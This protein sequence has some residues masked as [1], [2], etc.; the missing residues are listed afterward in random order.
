MYKIISDNKDY[1]VLNKESGVIIHPGSGIKE[2]TLIEEIVEKYPEIKN[3]G[4]D[5]KRPG[6]VQRL[7]KEASGLMVIAKNTTFF[8]YLK[9]QFQDRKVKKEYTALVYGQIAK[10]KDII[11]FPIKRASSGHK[12]AA[13]PK[14][15]VG[16]PQN[17]RSRGNLVASLRAKDAITEFSI[18]KR[19]INYTLL[20]ITIE[21]GRT[22]QIRVHMLAY[23]HPLVGDHLYSTKKTRIKNKKINLGRIFLNAT[24]LSFKDRNNKTQSFSIDLPENLEKTLLFVKINF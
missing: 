21:T 8:E 7:D 10:E 12:M 5:V 1:L 3:V 14:T 17:A 11:D 6:I 4:D 22:H 24:K 15:N 20:K 19:Y 9:K 16:S 13:M 18:I 2:K 23:G